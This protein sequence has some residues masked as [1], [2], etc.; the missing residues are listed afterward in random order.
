MSANTYSFLCSNVPDRPTMFVTDSDGELVYLH[1]Y[2]CGEVYIKA[3]RDSAVLAKDPSEWL[4]WD[5]D[6][7]DD[8][9]RE[10]YEFARSGGGADLAQGDGDGFEVLTP[11]DLVNYGSPCD[12][13]EFAAAFYLELYRDDMLDNRGKAPAPDFFER[14]SD[15]YKD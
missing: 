7:I 13:Y 2:D 11:R 15:C 3:G 10:L 6:E 1:V 9:A 5:S 12:F 4:S 8:G 14:F